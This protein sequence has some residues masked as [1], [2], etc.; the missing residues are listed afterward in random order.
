VG[1]STILLGQAWVEPQCPDEASLYLSGLV[2]DEAALSDA[3]PGDSAS[4]AVKTKYK[5]DMVTVMEKVN[6]VL[7]EYEGCWSL[8]DRTVWQV[9][10][11]NWRAA[12]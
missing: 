6:I 5:R 3:Y 12:L 10:L 9:A 2:V 1:A 4:P 7:E 8:E 11:K